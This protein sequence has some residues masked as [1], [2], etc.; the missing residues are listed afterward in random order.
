LKGKANEFLVGKTLPADFDLVLDTGYAFTSAYGLRWN[1]PSETAF[2]STFLI[3]KDG[4]IFFSKIAREHDGRTTA[5]EVI[6]AMP[7]RTKYDETRVRV[8]L[9]KPKA[10]RR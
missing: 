10:K 6:E 3:G 4:L 9:R 5:A 7:R 8:W 2:P 1:T